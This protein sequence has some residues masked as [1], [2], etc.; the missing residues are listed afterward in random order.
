MGGGVNGLPKVL[1]R[2]ASLACLALE[3]HVAPDCPWFRGHFPGH[4]ILPGVV[5]IGWA[6]WFGARWLG[7]GTPP[8]RLSRIK[9]RRPIGP[10]ARLSL[11]LRHDRGKLYYDYLLLEATGAVSASSG[12]FDDMDGS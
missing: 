3:L 10:D 7:C 5:Q 8:R 9:F 4:P 11:R 6:A 1:A 12:C 2:D